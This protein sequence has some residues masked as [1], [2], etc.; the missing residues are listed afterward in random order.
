MEPS[1]FKRAWWRHTQNQFGYVLYG[2]EKADGDCSLQ[3]LAEG[4]EEAELKAR[5]LGARHGLPA[6]SLD[7]AE[8][9][10]W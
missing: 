4:A 7:F 3:W 5:E 8:R 1:E 6:K 9:P 2:L 10:S